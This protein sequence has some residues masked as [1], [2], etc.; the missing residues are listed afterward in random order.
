VKAHIFDVDHTV[1]AGSTMRHFLLESLGSGVVPL[2]RLRR[3]P[4]E[5]LKYKM[6]SPDLD[7][8]ENA[9][10]LTAGMGE[11]DLERIARASFERRVARDVFPGA[12]ALVREA[13]ARGEPVV[14]ASSS[15]RIA[16]DPLAR[17]LGVGEVLACELEFAG[18]RTTGRLV[19]KS[20]FGPKKLEVAREWMERRGVSAADVSFY[21]DSYVDI[22]LL[23]FC[24]RAVAVNPD[25]ALERESRK[26][27]WEIL[28]FARSRFRRSFGR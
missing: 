28:R 1:T 27:G 7:F 13:V 15:F 8:I 24:G 22:P 3:L 26:R 16:L 25:R 20:P 5:W 9:V 2:R 21:S 17:H 14:F 19:G 12:E 18:G 4:L 23:E 11:S 10:R 6:G